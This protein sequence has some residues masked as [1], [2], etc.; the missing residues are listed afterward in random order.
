MTTSSRTPKE[1]P[2]GFPLPS[3]DAT[4]RTIQVGAKVRI[5]S[6]A[7]C[8]KGLPAEDQTGLK[9]YEGRIFKVEDIDSYGMVWFGSDGGSRNFSL[10][11]NEVAVV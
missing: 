11:P 1:L 9:S 6:V 5:I 2:P 8:A 7:S 3:V 10:L 4:G